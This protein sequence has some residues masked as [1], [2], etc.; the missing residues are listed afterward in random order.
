[1]VLYDLQRVFIGMP[2][3]TMVSLTK[4]K[5]YYGILEMA[6]PWY[7]DTSMV[8]EFNSISIQ[9]HYGTATGHEVML[10]IPWY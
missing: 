10:Y 1:M 3:N 7:S 4:T 2:K 8:H 5:Y 9:N 6:F